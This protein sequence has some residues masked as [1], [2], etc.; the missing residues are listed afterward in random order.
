MSDFPA[1]S[2]R[3]GSELW[4][5]GIVDWSRAGR[6][7]AVVVVAVVVVVVVAKARVAEKVLAGSWRR[8]Y[9]TFLFVC[10]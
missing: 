2:L 1:V 3:A 4:S 9:K 7:V 6:S 10:Q 8:R 5:V